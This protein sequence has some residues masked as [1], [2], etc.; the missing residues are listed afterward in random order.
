MGRGWSGLQGNAMAAAV[1]TIALRADESL[2]QGIAHNLEGFARE[3]LP[4]GVRRHAAVAV[5]IAAD[6]DDRACFV[7]TRRA[8]RMREHAGQ[9]ALPGGRI[10]GGESSQTTALRELAEEVGVELGEETVLGTL[11]DYATRSGYVITPVVIWHGRR[12]ELTPNPREVAAA[13]HVPLEVLGWPEVPHIYSIPES[14]RPVIQVPIAQLNTAIHAPTAAILYQL[15]E[16]A[17]QGRSTRVAH[18]DQPVFAWK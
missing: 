17:V 11:D 8:S 18:Y 5:V 16:V 14:D 12:A 10:E 13:Y 3:T 7:I 2:R 6:A 15:W 9:W 4:L 1:S